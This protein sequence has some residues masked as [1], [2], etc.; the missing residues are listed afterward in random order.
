[1]RDQEITRKQDYAVSLIIEFFIFSVAGWVF[2]TIYCS[3][4]EQR[5]VE[6]GFLLGPYCP[7]YG[8]AVLAALLLFGRIK[9][10]VVLFFV[11]ALTVSVV[12]YFTSFA[13]EVIYNWRWWD[14]S[15]LP[16]NL[17]GRICLFAAIFFGCGT[18]LAVRVLHPAL[19]AKLAY[20]PSSIRLAMGVGI[21]ML[22]FVDLIITHIG[23]WAIRD[24]LDGIYNMISESAQAAYTSVMQ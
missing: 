16:F 6:R 15:N 8:F 12:E 3:I 22:L 19:Q 20:I 18:L 23:L 4:V 5:L 10:N 17:D 14:Y 9:N 21:V 2:E 13:L 11:S 7:I 1:M 24:T